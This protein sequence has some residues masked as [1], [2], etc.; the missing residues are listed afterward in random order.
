M[1]TTDSVPPL[2]AVDEGKY[3]D[4]FYYGHVELSKKQIVLV[5]DRY[6]YL[7]QWNTVVP[8]SLIWTEG[9]L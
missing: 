5:L 6:I 3:V 7:T 1:C 9:K 8:R 4:Q 2:Q